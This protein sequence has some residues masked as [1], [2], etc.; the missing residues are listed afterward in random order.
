M[1]QRGA[2]SARIS[3]LPPPIGPVGRTPPRRGGLIEPV[4][5]G[6]ALALQTLSERNRARLK[7]VVRALSLLDSPD[8]FRALKVSRARWAAAGRQLSGRQAYPRHIVQI[9]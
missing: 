4:P 1:V 9:T 2:Q 3:M 5:R 8:F 7:A 6:Q